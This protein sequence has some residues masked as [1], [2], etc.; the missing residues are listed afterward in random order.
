MYCHILNLQINSLGKFLW[1]AY[2]DRDGTLQHWYRLF[3]PYM[4]RGVWKASIHQT[5]LKPAWCEMCW[6]LRGRGWFLPS[7]TCSQPCTQIIEIKRWIVLKKH[8][9]KTDQ[10]L[11]GKLRTESVHLIEQELTR[12][13]RER[14]SR[15]REYH[16]YRPEVLYWFIQQICLTYVYQGVRVGRRDKLED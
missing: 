11:G 6:T 4:V 14:H 3:S 13:I 2:D 7:W 9:E 16:V 10:F 8:I 12:W 5:F 15:P 1:F